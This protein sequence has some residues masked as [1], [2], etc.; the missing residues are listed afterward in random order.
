MD[1]Q[2]KT[3]VRSRFLLAE[4][5]EPVFDFF[6]DFGGGVVEEAVGFGEAAV[7]KARFVGTGF[8][9]DAGGLGMV[10][11][12]PLGALGAE[13][14]EG[15]G[16]KGG[17]E[18][19]GTGVVAD[20]SGC[21][22]QMADEFGEVGGA[23][24][25][26]ADGFPF[27]SLV[28]VAE[29]LGW[30][31]CA[32]KARG[33][34]REAGDW[35]DADWPGGAGVKEGEALRRLAESG[36]RRMEDGKAERTAKRFPLG[37]ARGV[38][39]NFGERFGEEKLAAEAGK[40]DAAGRSGKPKDKVVTRVAAG[41]DGNARLLPADLPQ[42]RLERPP[43][44]TVQSVFTGES[45]PRGNHREDG[46]LG[47]KFFGEFDGVGFGEQDDAETAAGGLKEGGTD[48]QIADAPK[49][50]DEECFHGAVFWAMR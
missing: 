35:P 44:P 38:G 28:G 31:A 46:D 11:E 21:V 29:D 34:L 9:F 49:F 23:M 41:G 16:A 22:F 10:G 18:M 27:L 12:E 48:G 4:L 33:E 39:R 14:G 26:V 6:G 32:L 47:P 37:G 43:R 20:E 50:G 24:G 7:V 45:G 36:A 25:K 13:D 1:K 40:A 19:A 3:C 15:G 42:S 5:L 2:D 30:P 8:A 17:G